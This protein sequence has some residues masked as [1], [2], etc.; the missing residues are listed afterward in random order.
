MQKCMMVNDKNLKINQETEIVSNK[1]IFF[2]QESPNKPTRRENTLQENFLTH[3]KAFHCH[4]C[5]TDTK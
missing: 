4:L 1:S 5:N 3:T 2:S